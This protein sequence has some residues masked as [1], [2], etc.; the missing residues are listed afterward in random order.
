MDLMRMFSDRPGH[1]GAQAADAAH[2][3]HHLH[4]GAR[5]VVQQ[6]DQRLV[7]QLV[8]LQPD[9]GRLAGMRECD[10]APDQ[11]EQHRRAWSAD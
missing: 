1:A 2:H 8:H 10:L 7:D 5:R 6:V 3:A 11:V 9:A 4:A